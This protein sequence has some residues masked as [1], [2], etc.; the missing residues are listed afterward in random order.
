VEPTCRPPPLIALGPMRQC[1]SSTCRSC[2]ARTPRDASSPLHLIPVPVQTLLTS[3][4]FPTAL[5][6]PPPTDESL[7]LI[8]LRASRFSADPHSDQ[9]RSDSLHCCRSTLLH[10][11]LLSS[12]VA[13]PSTP[14]S[15]PS[16]VSPPRS[17]HCHATAGNKVRRI[18][19]AYQHGLLY[20]TAPPANPQRRPP[21]GAAHCQCR[22]TTPTY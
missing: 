15:S 8:P 1:S 9:R 5:V 4:S 21:D 16:V 3:S 14:L 11:F 7:C 18:A 13:V 20:A 10:P 2:R 17:S 19:P 12:A 6:G 22:V